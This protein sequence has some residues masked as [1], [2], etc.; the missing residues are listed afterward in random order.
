MIIYNRIQETIKKNLHKMI[1]QVVSQ[2][3]K[4]KMILAKSW[5]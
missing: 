2:R 3:K 1:T 5:K 4:Q